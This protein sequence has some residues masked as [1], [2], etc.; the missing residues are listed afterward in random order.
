MFGSEVL[1]VGVGLVFVF[2]LLS[3]ACSAANELLEAAVKYRARALELGLRELLDD[4][5]AAGLVR[6]LYGHPLVSGLFRGAYDPNSKGNLPTYIPARTFALALMDVLQP[7]SAT[8]L[9]GAAGALLTPLPSTPAPAVPNAGPVQQFRQT[10]AGLPA[11]QVRT[12]LLSLIDAA[13]DDASRARQNIEDW[14]NTSMDRVSGW[15]KRRTQAIIAV[16]GLTLVVAVNADT[17]GIARYL[18]TNKTARALIVSQAES[19]V[20]PAPGQ[21]AAVPPDLKTALQQLD[22]EGALPLG[23]KREATRDWRRVPQSPGEWALK[24][25][26]LLLT[27]FA[28]SLGAPFWFD[29]LNKIMVVRSTIKSEDKAAP[30][31]SKA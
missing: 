12:A 27:T 7:A 13:G 26:G 4:P 10:I 22:E 17:V 11:S 2:L 9:S 24:I 14:Y 28:V 19:A 16:I 29:M 15:Y 3:L 30:Q 8:V 21:P 5:Q 20:R 23:W 1:D 18:S 6:R 25:L 31:A